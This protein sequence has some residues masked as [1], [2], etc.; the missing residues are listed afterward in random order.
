[1]RLGWPRYRI[2][3]GGAWSRGRTS[4]RRLSAVLPIADPDGLLPIFSERLRT[5]RIIAAPA[6]ALG[7]AIVP[8]AGPK[9]GSG[10]C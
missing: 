4:R 2:L 10:K 5:T 6:S 9:R 7:E 8:V 1:M 3:G